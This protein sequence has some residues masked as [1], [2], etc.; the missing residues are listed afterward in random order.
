MQFFFSIVNRKSINE[1]CTEPYMCLSGIG[2]SCT[3]SKCVCAY[4][5]YWNGYSCCDIFF[6]NLKEN[7]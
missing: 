7:V 5:H 6:F 3:S 1:S 2:L 4:T